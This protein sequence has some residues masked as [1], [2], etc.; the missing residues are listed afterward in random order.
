[1]RL[2][3]VSLGTK[4]TGLAL[5]GIAVLVATVAAGGWGWMRLSAATV[6]SSTAR[7]TSESFAAIRLAER[8]WCQYFATERADEHA[9]ACD[10]LSVILARDR[11][12]GSAAISEALLTYRTGFAAL[13]AAQQDE[14]RIEQRMEAAIAE[15]QRR[16]DAMVL[17][18][19][20][21]Q[22]GLQQE[23]EDL[24]PDEFNLLASL[25]DG[26]T[27]TLRLGISY[28]R[29]QLSGDTAHL[30]AFDNLL[31][32]EGMTARNCI[33]T[34]SSSKATAPLWKAKAEPVVAAIAACAE[35]PGLARTNHATFTAAQLSLDGFAATLQQAV[36]ASRAAA[37]A[38]IIGTQRTVAWV[39]G[40]IVLIAPLILFGVSRL[41]V[42]AILRPLGQAMTLAEAIAKGDFTNRA[43]IAWRDETGR[44]AETLNGMSGMLSERI[45]KVAE[46]AGV[47]GTDAARLSQLADRMSASA[48]TTANEAGTVRSVAQEVSTSINAVAAATTEMEASITEVARSAS[49]AAGAAEAGVKETAEAN[50]TVAKLSASSREIGEV[51]QLIA[52]IA[53]QTNLL[54][55]N[56]TIEAARA[57]DAG[58]GFAVVASEVK[59]LARQT[60]KATAEI[61]AKVQGIQGDAT[62]TSEAIV[63][64]SSQITRIADAQR[65]V[66]AA[67]EEQ[68]ATTR[69]IAGSASKAAEGGGRI[70]SAAGS[71]ASAAAEASNGA[72]QTQGAARELQHAADQLK[73]IVTQFRL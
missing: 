45:G 58:R 23:G 18:I 9:A 4:L 28:K 14:R 2:T 49:D 69:E 11:S 3:D 50:Q 15:V 16:V 36:D 35:L 12:G 30:A 17:D 24:L 6:V 32:K 70:A 53:E 57:G 38:T 56:A 31:A 48:G 20:K 65:Q 22:T 39:V 68:S 10:S 5:L 51:V 19:A 60:A 52:S 63:R 43:E 26:T 25:R 34:F 41:L 59:E 40:A 55:L 13:V 44:L 27:I 72:S 21:R 71:V 42:R 62:A 67:V 73:A 54:A 1:M 7:D 66:A 64:I 8:A 29:F 61:T 33:A 47:V 37:N 46:Q